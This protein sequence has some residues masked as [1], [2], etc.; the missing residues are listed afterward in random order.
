MAKE[1]TIKQ[2][3]VEGEIQDL[4]LWFDPNIPRDGTW[5]F[6]GDIGDE[7]TAKNVRIYPVEE[8]KVEDDDSDFFMHPVWGKCL[9]YDNSRYFSF[10]YN[11]PDLEFS[12]VS[13]FKYWH[14][15]CCNLEFNTNVIIMRKPRPRIIQEIEEFTK[16]CSCSRTTAFGFVKECIKRSYLARFE[17]SDKTMFVASPECT[18]N[19]SGLPITLWKLFNFGK[20]YLDS[21]GALRKIVQMDEDEVD[22]SDGEEE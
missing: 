6:A 1:T 18:R 3:N 5:R 14:E 19:G 22:E 8:R 2:I 7:N 16:I 17:V 4:D 9:K 12:K 20:E 10:R 13:Y 11:S 21:K 15:V